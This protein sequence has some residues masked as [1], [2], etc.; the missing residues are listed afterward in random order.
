VHGPATTDVERGTS[1]KKFV[2]VQPI[3][4]GDSLYRVSLNLDKVFE[5]LDGLKNITLPRCVA[6]FVP[7]FVSQCDCCRRSIRC[8]SKRASRSKAGPPS[9]TTVTSGL[10]LESSADVRSIS[11]T[12]HWVGV[13]ET[14]QKWSGKLQPKECA[15]GP[16]CRI[17]CLG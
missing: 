14:W 6:Q 16:E 2:L 10:S 12:W 5:A 4:V 11:M 3:L 17:A 8:C 15:R 9:P 7:S 13:R 1:Q